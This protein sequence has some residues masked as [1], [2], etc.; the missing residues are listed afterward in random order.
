[1]NED[2]IVKILNLAELVQAD[3]F[4]LKKDLE[5]TRAKIKRQKE[6]LSQLYNMLR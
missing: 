5:N 4:E 3:Y 1:M 6:Q 2:E